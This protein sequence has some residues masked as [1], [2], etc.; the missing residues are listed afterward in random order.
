MKKWFTALT[1]SLM[2]LS[3]AG[4]GHSEEK[5][6]CKQ[7]ESS[8]NDCCAQTVSDVTSEIPDCCG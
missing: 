4:C 1:V 6:C 8:V 2:I 5:D 3:L 7:T